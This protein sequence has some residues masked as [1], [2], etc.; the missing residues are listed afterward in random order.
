MCSKTWQC[1]QLCN[2]GDGVNGARNFKESI[3]NSYFCLKT[4]ECFQTSCEK[5]SQII[6]EGKGE[7]FKLSHQLILCSL[8]RRPG[9]PTHHDLE[10]VLFACKACHG[11]YS[12]RLEVLVF[13]VFEISSIITKLFCLFLRLQQ[14]GIC[15]RTGSGKSSLT[16]A[17]FRIIDTYRGKWRIT[18]RSKSTVVSMVQMQQNS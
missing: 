2:N 16:L 17:L 1:W 12:Y 11:G 4:H 5:Q 18:T 6:S 14:V 13:L 10:G 8:T 7:K 3:G 15:G 9:Y